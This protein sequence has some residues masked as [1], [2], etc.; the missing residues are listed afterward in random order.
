MINPTTLPKKISLFNCSFSI[1]SLYLCKQRDPQH[2][3]RYK[4]S[5]KMFLYPLKKI[6]PFIALFFA[7]TA[8]H[9]CISNSQSQNSTQRKNE[10]DSIVRKINDIES[11]K[12]ILSQYQVD[13]NIEGQMMTLKQLGKCQR[14]QNKF[15][16][17]IYSHTEG[18]KFAT[19][20]CDT[21]EI[22]YALNNIGT[23]YRRM[24]MLE[25]ATAYHYQALK[26]CEEYSDKYS[27]SAKKNRVVSLNGIGNIS[28]RLGDYETAD[29]VFRAALAGEKALGSAL[30]Q[31]INYANLGAIYEYNNQLDSAWSYYTQSMNK[32]IEAR[33][34]LGISLCHGYFGGLYEKAGKIDSAIIEYNKA[35]ALK[36]KIDAWH[37]LN[38]CLS[39][40]QLYLNQNNIS[41]AKQLLT[42][43]EDVAITSRSRDHSASIYA[44]LS[45]VYEKLGNPSM[46]FDYYK[47]SRIYNDSIVSEKN[48]IQVQNERVKYE[49]QR[50]QQEIDSLQAGYNQEKSFSNLM[51]WAMIAIAILS[52]AIILLLSYALQMRKKRHQALQQI[53]DVR[54]SFFTNITHEFRTPLTVIVG[55]SEELTRINGGG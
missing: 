23:N 35:F 27:Y 41:L 14:E 37:W 21:A 45:E 28:L 32:N 39:L 9:S 52:I 47:K 55:V 31:A 34:D 40:A 36:D 8:S 2:L 49:Y 29:S 3:F 42:Q 33:S 15:V 44:L 13:G 20:L 5:L 54:T 16:D 43:A 30:G 7:L 1:N 18:Q 53:D 46:A 11:L 38:S 12:T 4:I 6:F 50:R 17:A 10:V 19:E 51:V 26:Y 24:S 48:L 25:D 22:I